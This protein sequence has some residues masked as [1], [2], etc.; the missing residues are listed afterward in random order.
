MKCMIWD[1]QWFYCWKKNKNFCI[2]IWMLLLKVVVGAIGN[3]MIFLVLS[4]EF[5]LART[6]RTSYTRS[7]LQLIIFWRLQDF[8][9]MKLE[10]SQFSRKVN[11]PWDILINFLSLLYDFTCKF[12]RAKLR[13]LLIFAQKD[14]H[15]FFQH[16]HFV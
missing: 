12:G 6:S 10:Q 5:K 1:L 9:Q 8:L 14:M 3:V 11:Y 7:V 2:S 13:A 4:P 16:V 15:T